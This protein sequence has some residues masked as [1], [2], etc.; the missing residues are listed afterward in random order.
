MTYQP[1]KSSP[2]DLVVPRTHESGFGL[3]ESVVT[4]LIVSFGLLALAYMQSWG[5][6][7][8][9][10]AGARTQATMIANDLLDRIR[11]TGIATSDSGATT[12]T[13][14]PSGNLTC[15]PGTVSAANDRDCFY[16]QISERIPTAAG[17]IAIS[18]NMYVITIAWL[19]R[20]AEEQFD[21]DDNG[22]SQAECENNGRLW[23]D[24][25]TLRWYPTSAKPSKASCLVSQNWSLMQ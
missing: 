11:V 16:V 4:L 14:T 10:D 24:D 13:A 23:Y 25:N 18:G 22:L 2:A 21:S 15:A 12:Y 19:D 8:G 17:A 9:Q 1:K 20:Y 5:Q 6:R 3:I 7:F